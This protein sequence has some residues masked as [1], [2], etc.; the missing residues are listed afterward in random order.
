MDDSDDPAGSMLNK[1]NVSSVPEPLENI[2]GYRIRRLH[3]LFVAHWSG[4]FGVRGLSLTPV[5]GGILLLIASNSDSTQTALARQLKVEGP[6]L[7]QALAPLVANG[8][9]LRRSAPN[10]R[11]VKMLSLSP[12]GKRA[13]Q[14]IR[15]DLKQHEDD[16]LRMLTPRQ[17]KQ[18]FQLLCAA[19]RSAE[20]TVEGVP[21][22]REND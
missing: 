13:T 5:Q 8:Y 16:L 15:T 11:R 1:M 19:L 14:I 7:L 22:K 3:S 10:D 9:V 6:T 12:A 20:A 17:R 18:F 4:W 21:A 2:T